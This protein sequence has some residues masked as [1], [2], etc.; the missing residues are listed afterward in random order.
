MHLMKGKS[1]ALVEVRH[2]AIARNLQQD[3]DEKDVQSA[4]Q[5]WAYGCERLCKFLG[6]ILLFQNSE[7]PELEYKQIIRIP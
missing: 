2:C 1:F 5:G 7:R 3:Y 4:A 6:Y